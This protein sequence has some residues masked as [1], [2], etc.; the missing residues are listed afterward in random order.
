M[1]RSWLGL[2]RQAAGV[3]TV[4][5]GGW[6]IR[7]LR[8]APAAVGADRRDIRPVAQRSPNYRDGAFVNLDPASMISLDRQQQW[9]LAREFLDGRAATR[10]AAPIPLVTPNPADHGVGAADLAVRWY[11]H[12]TAMVEVDGYRVLTDPIWSRRCSPSALVGPRRL[13][14]PPTPLEALPAVDAVLISHD[15]YDHL[16]MDTVVRLARTQ[17]APF[18]VPLGVGAHLRTWRIPEHRIVE[19]DW[20]ESRR[21]GDLRITCTPARHF[22]GRLFA[23]NTTLWASWVIAGPR[24]RAFFGGDTG[25]TKSFTEIGVDH[26]PFDL[27]LLPIGAYH[28]AWPDIHM[29]PEEAVRAHLDMAEADSGLLVPIHWATFRLA[30]HPWSE[31][32]ER[33]LAAADPARVPV[34]VPRPGERVDRD[35]AGA[36]DQWWRPADGR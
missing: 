24:H 2:M 5:G 21:I 17:R 19:L 16:D 22:S 29:N 27:T 10:P 3:A 7:A 25:Y 1:S 30:P 33:L 13:H 8:G 14:E 32:V 26:G 9:V 12:S 36:S 18:L 35:S 15:H 23:R 6:L 20:Y 28:P 4:L 31:P 11:G 34:A